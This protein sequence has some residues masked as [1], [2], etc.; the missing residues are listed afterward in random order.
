MSTYSWQ[1]INIEYLK[2]NLTVEVPTTCDLLQMKPVP[3]LEK[4]AEEIDYAF[5]NPIQSKRIED[6]VSSHS[7]PADELT[8]AIVVSDNTRPIPYNC[9]NSENILSPIL[10][11]LA[12]AGIQRQHIK[13]I[14]GTGTHT[15]TTD[16]WKREVFGDEIFNHYQLLDHDCYSRDLVSIGEVKGI[17]VKINRDFI[18]SDL[19]IVTG[20][21]EAHFMAGASGGR[22]AICPG[23]VN[24]EATQVFH[25]PEFMAD[26]NADNLIFSH[27]PCHEFALEVARRTRVDFAVN[28]LLNGDLHICG[29]T[30][31]NLEESHQKVV[32]Q[33]RLFSELTIDHK[34]DVVLTHGG[35]GALNHYQ[36]IKGAWAALPAVKKG[37]YIILL[38]HNQDREPIGSQHYKDLLKKLKEVGVGN[39]SSL[40]LSSK[41]DFTHDQWEVQK[42]EQLFLRIGGEEHLIYCTVNIPPEILV[43]LPVVSGY[44]FIKEY[45]P[46]IT[47]MLQQAIY[48]CVL[49]KENTSMAFLREGPYLVIKIK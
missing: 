23:L 40:L 15:P 3:P 10:S 18:Q 20:L 32:N 30:T 9:T 12:T 36:A 42:W 29:I 2:N 5:Q 24:L 26:P 6:I 8:V 45:P 43:T 13:I 39:F 28:V 4:V 16:S 44:Q 35:K 1:K 48:H 17:P 11:R 33:L 21:V 19:H 41:W 34:Y 14:I 31:G 22:K 47:T 37:G 38:A 46:D 49:K 25:G 27:N 7:K